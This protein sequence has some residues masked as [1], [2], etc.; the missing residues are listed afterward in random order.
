LDKHWKSLFWSLIAK[1]KFAIEYL[2]QMDS[3]QKPALYSEKNMSHSVQ[4]PPEGAFGP[5]PI[6]DYPL[7]DPESSSWTDWICCCCNYDLMALEARGDT[8]AK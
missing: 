5:G 8:F 2:F 1:P 4:T 7:N 6:V 3:T